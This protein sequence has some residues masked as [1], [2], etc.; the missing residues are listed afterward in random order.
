MQV[1]SLESKARFA[2][3]KVGLVARKSR[4]YA[5]P[6]LLGG[7]MLVDPETGFPVAGFHYDLEPEGVIRFCKQYAEP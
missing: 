4:R 7:F 2:A 6:N 5:P 3:K 1:K